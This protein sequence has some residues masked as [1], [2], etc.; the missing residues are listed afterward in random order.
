MTDLEK[1]KALAEQLTHDEIVDL[2]S[3]VAALENRL[4]RIVS[5]LEYDEV[6]RGK[7]D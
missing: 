7:G 5:A 3:Y 6:S 4:A 2:L 1:F